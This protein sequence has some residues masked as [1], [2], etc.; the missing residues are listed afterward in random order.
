M[1]DLT[2]STATTVVKSERKAPGTDI[3][4]FELLEPC[5]IEGED[6]LFYLRLA[7]QVIVTV[8]PIDVVEEVLVSDYVNYAFDVLRL[9]RLKNNLLRS[10]APAGLASALSGLVSRDVAQELIRKWYAGDKAGLKNEL[11]AAGLT[12][13]AVMAQTLA[14]SLDDLERMDRLLQVAERRRDAALRELERRR[15]LTARKAVSRVADAACKLAPQVA[16]PAVA[17]SPRLQSP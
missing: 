16:P 4:A 3:L 15:P 13:D 11:A 12:I 1:H 10:R 2:P 7:G 8:V 9:R 17:D 5:V 6:L 14:H